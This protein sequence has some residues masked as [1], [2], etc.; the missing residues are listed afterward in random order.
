M[1]ILSALAEEDMQAAY[2]DLFFKNPQAALNLIEEIERHLAILEQFPEAGHK[3]WDLTEKPVRFW[4]IGN[5]LVVI[6]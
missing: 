3:R 6:K 2:D 4:A 1:I 5:Y